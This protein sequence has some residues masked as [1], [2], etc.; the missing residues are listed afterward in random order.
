MLY[1]FLFSQSNLGY[2]VS[3]VFCGVY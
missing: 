1:V 2:N 3:V